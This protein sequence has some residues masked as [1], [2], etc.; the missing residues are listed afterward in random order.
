MSDTPSPLRARW[1]AMAP[2]ERRMVSIAAV[3]V[4]LA[5]LWWV[6]LGPALRT[7]AAAPSEHARLDAELQKMTTLQARAKALQALPRAN[8]DDSLRAL[9]TSV[10][11][12]LGA[13]AQLLSAGSGDAANVT[14]RG[15]SADALAQWLAQARAN[16]RAVPREAHLNRTLVAPAS[17]GAAAR[18]GTKDDPVRWEGNLVMTLPAAAR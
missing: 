15:A 5:L 7:L 16:A 1:A 12:S 13:G 11:E 8:R 17:P 2:R 6:A 4:V 18:A 9:D 10:R 14:L 3:L